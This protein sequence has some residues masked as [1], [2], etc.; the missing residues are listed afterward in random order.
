MTDAAILPADVAWRAC[1]HRDAEPIPPDFVEVYVKSSIGL[2]VA[3]IGHIATLVDTAVLDAAP[4]VTLPWAD[5]TVLDVTDEDG[6]AQSGWTRDG[7]LLTGTWTGALLTV[8]CRGV[9]PADVRLAASLI[10][11]QLWLADSAG[12]AGGRPSGEEKVPQDRVPTRAK[13]LLERWRG[14]GFA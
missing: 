13:T 4:T 1:G 11:R 6:T 7:A 9:V 2:V 10:C 5:G 3:T 12:N 14:W 8:R